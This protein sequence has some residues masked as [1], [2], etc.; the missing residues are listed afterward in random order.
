MSKKDRLNEKNAEAKSIQQ[1]KAEINAEE[2]A[3]LKS[4]REQFQ[5]EYNELCQKH[6]CGLRPRV[7]F[8]EGL[9]TP[10]FVLEV[11]NLKAR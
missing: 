9:N 7:T 6:S 3:A 2:Q 5:K 1:K 10:S 4:I 8:I 11:V